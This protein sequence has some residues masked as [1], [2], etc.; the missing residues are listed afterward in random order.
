MT[1]TMIPLLPSFRTAHLGA[2]EH[3]NPSSD[4]GAA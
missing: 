2:P 4:H 3:E 1:C